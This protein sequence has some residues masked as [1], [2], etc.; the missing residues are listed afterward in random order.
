MSRTQG[1]PS[2]R[3]RGRIET[4]IA[5]AVGS[6]RFPV[7]PA[8]WLVIGLAV[9]YIV[10]NTVFPGPALTYT[11]GMALALLAVGALLLA[12]I[13]PRDLFLRVAL[14]SRKGAALLALLLIFIPGALLAGR[15][16]PLDA[17]GDLVYAP[18]SALAQELY[19]R[20]ALLVALTHICRDRA[21]LALVLQAAL[22]ALW[23]IR[24]FEATAILPALAV[25]A[26]T[27]GAGLAWGAQVQRDRTLV[28]SALEHTLF[29]IVQ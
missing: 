4:S 9:P 25:L 7:A 5:S 16:Q 21:R 12:G 27:F 1:A 10:L 18:V 2:S 3:N 14:P 11:L 22:F 29:L 28:W 24:V 17:L 20:S 26:L 19:F 8:A 23:H 6:A 15:G 13:A